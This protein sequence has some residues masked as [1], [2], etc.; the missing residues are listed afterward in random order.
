MI[1]NHMIRIGKFFIGTQRDLTAQWGQGFDVGSQNTRQ[2]FE[3]L[4]T[5]QIK[6][7]QR[8]VTPATLADTKARISELKYILG[9]VKK[10]DR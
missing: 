2:H 5:A 8:N 10:H 9:K 6:F 4:V 1:G 3:S 7:L